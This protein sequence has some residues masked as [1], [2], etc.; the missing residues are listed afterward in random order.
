[1]SEKLQKLAAL[2]AAT[3]HEVTPLPEDVRDENSPSWTLTRFPDGTEYKTMRYKDGTEKKFRN[4]VEVE[5][6]Q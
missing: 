3:T 1:M 5:K 2:K 6:F 4:G